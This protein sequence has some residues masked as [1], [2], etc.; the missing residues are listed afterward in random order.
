MYPSIPAEGEDGAI[1]ACERAL[2]TA[3]HDPD[4]VNWLKR[5]LKM[6]LEFNVFE[7][8]EK[9][10]QQMFGTAIGTRCAPPLF[11]NLYGRSHR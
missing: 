4:L 8:D 5:L 2:L 11:R 1:A 10:Y 7:W 9:L 6:V 3:G